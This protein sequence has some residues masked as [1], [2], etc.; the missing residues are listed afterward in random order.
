MFSG[1]NISIGYPTDRKRNGYHLAC[2]FD[3]AIYW[4]SDQL[5]I[6]LVTKLSINSHFSYWN[7][8]EDKVFLRKP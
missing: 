4:L 8:K 7:M 3:Q 6:N 1:L 5:L 2:G